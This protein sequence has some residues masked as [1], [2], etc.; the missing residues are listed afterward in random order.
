MAAY[1][2]NT[3]ETVIAMLASAAIGAP[4][5]TI[6]PE[7]GSEAVIG[8]LGQTQPAVLF[9]CEATFYN[10]KVHPLAAKLAAICTAIPS[11]THVVVAVNGALREEAS[12][13]KGEAA[14][15][16]DLPCKRISFEELLAT[17]AAP[18]QEDP[19][20]LFAQLPFGHPLYILYSSG[21]TGSPKCIVHSAGG[22]LLQHAKEHILHNDLR[23]HDVFLQYTTIG[24]MMWHWLVSAL[25]VGCTIVLYE[26]SPFKPSPSHLIDLIDR[27]GITVF[28]TSARYIQHLCE[29]AILPRIGPAS[30]DPHPSLRLICSTG[31][32]L[33]VADY[34]Y[35]HEHVKGNVQ[36]ASVTGGTDIISLFGGANPLLPVRAGEIQS[37]CLGM[38]VHAARDNPR[39][40]A[41]QQD[42]VL[43]YV[44]VEDEPGDLICTRPFP[45]MPLC[46]WGDTAESRLY[47]N[48]YF[49]RYAH[50]WHHGDFMTINSET[51]GITMLG[52]SDGTLNPA[53]VRFGSAELYNIVASSFAGPIADCLVVGVR[54]PA[55]DVDE[56][57]I[58]F[59]V[60]RAPAVLDAG[61]VEQIR[62]KVRSAL[63][64]RHV[65]ACIIEAPSVPYTSNGKKIEVAVKR[66]L[67]AL[68][69][70][71][72]QVVAGGPDGDDGLAFYRTLRP[73][74]LFKAPPAKQ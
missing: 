13:G 48:A 34:H 38:A 37:P 49:A 21:T 60:M 10:G 72:D 73:S 64:P 3:I 35:V 50:V 20:A 56:H 47:F 15:T 27:L 28:G 5:T 45:A 62:A 31:S 70:S 22:T 74:D 32:P 65:P 16:M 57:V 42:G 30:A 53:G 4:F 69:S 43:P 33:S 26:G 63:S 29:A 25:R 51:M 67:S 23:R 6:P 2:A 8:R 24:W 11:I 18:S 9:A 52:R 59:V 55:V 1:A 39:W 58:M 17:E 68:P 40:R 12:G 71:D 14:P 44:T 46:F 61:L 41:G 66:L 7:F 36:L 19:R 54:R